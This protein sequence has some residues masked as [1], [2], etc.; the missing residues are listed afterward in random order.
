VFGS[1]TID[2]TAVDGYEFVFDE[3]IAEYVLSENPRPCTP[4]AS[5]SRAIAKIIVFQ[6]NLESRE[7]QANKRTRFD[8]RIQNHKIN[9]QNLYYIFQILSKL[10]FEAF[11]WSLMINRRHTSSLSTMPTISTTTHFV[12]TKALLQSLRNGYAFDLQHNVNDDGSPHAMLTPIEED[13]LTNIIQLSLPFDELWARLVSISDNVEKPLVARVE[14]FF[15]L[16]FYETTLLAAVAQL[17]R[18]FRIV[19]EDAASLRHLPWSFASAVSVAFDFCRALFRCCSCA[20]VEKDSRS[21]Q[22]AQGG[23]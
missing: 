5:A 18:L 9:N 1:G 4:L 7:T 3:I 11:F 8:L 19:Q 23:V 17:T 12:T 15:L 13:A 6:R 2:T 21:V 16:A 20:K 14:A 10:K 22:P